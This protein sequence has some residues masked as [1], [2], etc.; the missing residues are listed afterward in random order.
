MV[1]YHKLMAQS[2]DL[3]KE[4]NSNFIERRNAVVER[5]LANYE[6]HG[7][8]VQNLLETEG[9]LMVHLPTTF[10]RVPGNGRDPF[11]SLLKDKNIAET[12]RKVAY[13][14]AQAYD[15]KAEVDGPKLAVGGIYV[16]W[17]RL[18]DRV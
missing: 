18:E 4:L 1:D 7:L 15:L 5:L 10:Y 16:S 8:T 14:T 2:S 3:K 17:V 9:V 11:A 13:G 6:S 12:V